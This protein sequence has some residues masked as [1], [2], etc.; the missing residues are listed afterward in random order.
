MADASGVRPSER[1]AQAAEGAIALTIDGELTLTGNAAVET[2]LR[3]LQR[4]QPA[5]RDC[6][7]GRSTANT[8]SEQTG[9]GIE[10]S[11]WPQWTRTSASRIIGSSMSRRG[12]EGPIGSSRGCGSRSARRRSAR[13]LE[14]VDVSYVPLREASAVATTRSPAR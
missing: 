7:L 10:M 1:W 9:A 6:L 5:I 11:E 3:E 2:S 14:L 12:P 13:H 4:K 8:A